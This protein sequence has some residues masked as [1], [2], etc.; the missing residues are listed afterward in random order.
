MILH[1]HS[2]HWM[3]AHGG[4]LEGFLVRKQRKWVE[5]A[6]VLLF[7][8]PQDMQDLRPKGIDLGM[9]TSNS[10]LSSYFATIPGAPN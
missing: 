8:S 7:F 6:Y 3:M 1:G 10:L 9:K 2:I 4:W 5:V